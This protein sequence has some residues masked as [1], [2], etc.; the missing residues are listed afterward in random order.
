MSKVTQF[1]PSKLLVST[2]CSIILWMHAFDAM[3]P[4]KCNSVSSQWL[5]RNY[6]CDKIMSMLQGNLFM[7]RVRPSSYDALGRLLSTQQARSYIR[8]CVYKMT[9]A[10]FKTSCRVSVLLSCSAVFFLS[11]IWK[12]PAKN[13]PIF[14]LA[15]TF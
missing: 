13:C 1:K 14:L 12:K 3:K 6:K 5:W 9:S 7:F 4:L 2:A 8:P 15:L 11:K 10:L